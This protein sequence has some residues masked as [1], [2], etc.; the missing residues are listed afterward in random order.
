MRTEPVTG[1]SVWRADELEHSGEW[2]YRFTSADLDELERGVESVAGRD[3][4]R[5][6][7]DAF[8]MPGLQARVSGFAD[9]LDNGRGFVVLRG[10]PVGPRFDRSAAAAVFWAIC[11]RIGR[12]VPTTC[13]GTLLNHVYDRGPGQ[14]PN[15]RAYTT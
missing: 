5:L 8:E 12:L 3:V 11:A 15:A 6:S 13:D 14:D 7:P 2:I 1:P 9:E 10:L 4:H